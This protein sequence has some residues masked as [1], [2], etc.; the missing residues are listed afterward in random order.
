I[1]LSASFERQNPAALLAFTSERNRQVDIFLA[2]SE[3]A[4]NLGITESRIREQSLM[5]SEDGRY[6][7]FDLYDSPDT[8]IMLLD[9]ADWTI[10]ELDLREYSY[11]FWYDDNQLMVHR[12]RLDESVLLNVE[13]GEETPY[14]ER[15]CSDCTDWVAAYD[16][17]L[18]ILDDDLYVE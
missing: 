16:L 5:W 4:I 1:Y 17:E 11:N 7:S 3:S 8:S 6:L 12:N 14:V 13:T 9:T 18:S 15:Q 2:D 10:S